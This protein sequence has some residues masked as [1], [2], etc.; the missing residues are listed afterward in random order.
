MINDNNDGDEDKMLIVK[1]MTVMIT[2]EHLPPDT[3]AFLWPHRHSLLFFS[4]HPDIHD[5]SSLG[6]WL[7]MSNS[8]HSYTQGMEMSSGCPHKYTNQGS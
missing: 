6:E 8:S 2:T 3:F 4:N 5:S 7:Y 1:I